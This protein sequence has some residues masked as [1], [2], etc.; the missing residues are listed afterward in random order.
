M[1]NDPMNCCSEEKTIG[2]C[3]NKA[4][5]ALVGIAHATEPAIAEPLRR[6]VSFVSADGMATPKVDTVQADAD[7]LERRKRTV[8]VDFRSADPGDC[9]PSSEG[10]VT[11]KPKRTFVN[12]LKDLADFLK[13]ERRVL[14]DGE[15][16]KI[17]T[18]YKAKEP[19]TELVAEWRNSGNE[20]Y[21]TMLE[22]I[23]R[24]EDMEAKFGPWVSHFGG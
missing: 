5:M 6:E 2:C 14:R 24:L 11:K 13:Q 7:C 20:V 10:P 17:V 19:D 9:C 22:K 1:D 3:T 23:R 8:S 15:T 21:A 16:T 4:A 18:F 12:D